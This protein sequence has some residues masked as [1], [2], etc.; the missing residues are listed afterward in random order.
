MLS[1]H[2]HPLINTYRTSRHV[3]KLRRHNTPRDKTMRSAKTRSERRISGNC[4]TELKEKKKPCGSNSARDTFR[5]GEPPRILSAS[6]LVNFRCLSKRRTRKPCRDL[7]LYARV[8]SI[9]RR[10]SLGGWENVARS[11]A[12][13]RQSRRLRSRAL[14][15]CRL[16][17]T[18]P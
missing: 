15:I 8:S 9:E 10:R 3:N 17:Q 18:P 1:Y 2:D 5:M 6:S 14:I 16:R 7:R 4:T 13:R 12:R 11:K